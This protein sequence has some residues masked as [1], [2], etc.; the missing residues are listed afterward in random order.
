MSRR[1]LVPV[2]AGWVMVLGCADRGVI[3]GQAQ[4]V[5]PSAAPDEV[6]AAATTILQ[7]E[8]GRVRVEPG[9]RQITAG[10]VE[11]TTERDSGTARD[12]VRGRSTMRRQ[13][14]FSVG[15]SGGE[16]VARLRIDVERRD[17]ERQAVFRPQTHRLS[18]TPGQETPIFADAATTS[19]QNT[20]WTPI[21]RDRALERA[22]LDELREHFARRTAPAEP[23]P[24]P[25]APP[26]VSAPAPEN[27]E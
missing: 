21:R 8:F 2:L 11:F 15:R 7:R 23:A 5:V 1:A 9:T 17:T 12:L 26:A 24:E 6:L 14:T 22:L 4:R 20:V 3:E 16:T 25:A 18:D 13:A 19:E 10:P 27:P